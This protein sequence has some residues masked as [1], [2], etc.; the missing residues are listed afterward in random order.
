MT[1]RR[2]EELLQ[3]FPALPRLTERQIEA[4]RSHYELL[5][6][7]NARINL[8][9]VIELQEAVRFHYGE[10]LFLCS[11]IPAEARTVADVGSGAGF[12][13]FVIA[14]ARPDLQVTMIE[15]DQRKAAFLREA[16]DLA[17][18]ARVM[19]KRSSE[20]VGPFDV[21]VARAVRVEEVMEFARRACRWVMW[22]GTETPRG[23]TG[24][25]WGVAALPDGR[26]Q[27]WLARMETTSR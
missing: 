27:V 24:L 26:G 19:A 25:E 4:L 5:E 17:P 10:S 13:G 20:V 14:V 21:A 3:R 2:F 1:R 23:C 22:I 9:R 16:S 11:L 7:W 18:N 6:R 8:T 15:S 12:P